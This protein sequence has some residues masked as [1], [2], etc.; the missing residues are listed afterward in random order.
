MKISFNEFS[1]PILLRRDCVVPSP[2]SKSTSSS[3]KMAGKERSGE[4]ALPPE[5]IRTTFNTDYPPKYLV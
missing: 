4:I 5:P 3:T 1:D 2:Q